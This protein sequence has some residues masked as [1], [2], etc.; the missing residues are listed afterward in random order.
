M[1]ANTTE[2]VDERLRRGF[3]THSDADLERR[4]VAKQRLDEQDKLVGIGTSQQEIRAVCRRL[5]Q[6]VG[7]GRRER[8]RAKL[9]RGSVLHL[10]HLQNFRPLER[11]Q[12]HVLYNRIVLLNR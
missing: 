8:L 11:T 3:A 9:A 10:A 7:G 5:V 2:S 4:A 6:E 12:F 1:E